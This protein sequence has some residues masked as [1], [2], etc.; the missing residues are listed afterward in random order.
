MSS[1]FSSSVVTGEMS[2]GIV[3]RIEQVAGNRIFKK[4]KEILVQGVH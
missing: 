1:F 3:E 2:W 4:E